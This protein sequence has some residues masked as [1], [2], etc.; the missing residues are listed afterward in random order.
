MLT[1]NFL[2]ILTRWVNH[3]FNLSHIVLISVVINLMVTYPIL[4][5]VTSEL[6]TPHDD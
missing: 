2:L 4:T 3:F 1:A 5:I 6:R